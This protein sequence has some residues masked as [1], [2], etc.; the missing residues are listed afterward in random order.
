MKIKP[1]IFFLISLIILVLLFLF[2]AREGITKK[3]QLLDYYGITE[4]HLKTIEKEEDLEYNIALSKRI[5]NITV[6]DSENNTYLLKELLNESPKMIVKF[7]S[8]ECSYCIEHIIKYTKKYEEKIG[9]DNILFLGYFTGKKDFLIF[10]RLYQLDYNVF[11][12][13]N[14]GL[15]LPLDYLN[16]PYIVIVDSTLI[17]KETFVPMKSKPERT[18]KY[19]RE[20][21]RF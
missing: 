12:I 9:V 2:F 17:P 16:E 8:L 3:Q 11:S 10:N 21:I 4:N 14:N 1:F 20:R 5:E 6:L 7:S 18:E 19:F 13:P 15:D